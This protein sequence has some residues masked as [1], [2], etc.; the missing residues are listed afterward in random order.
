MNRILFF[1]TFAL[2]S[3]A[4]STTSEIKNT[5]T[6]AA[7]A[8]SAIN[9]KPTTQPV[10]EEV[11]TSG[12]DPRADIISAAQKLQ[13][14]P[15]WTAKVSSETNTDANAEMEYFAPDRF[16]IKKNDGEVVVIGNDSYSNEDGK[17]TKLDDNIGEIIRNSTKAGIE[18]GVKNLKDVKIVGK[19]KFNGKDATVYSHEIGGV[20]TKIWIGSESGLQLKNEVEAN[21]AGGVQKQTTVYDYD[22][23]VSIEAPKIN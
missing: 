23:K 12:T 3:T 22:K 6:N 15:F 19:E 2:I 13:K 18:E 20:K 17:W 11:Y 4:C 9:A 5:T 14:M 7:P 10:K 8:N 16:R 1:I 21:L